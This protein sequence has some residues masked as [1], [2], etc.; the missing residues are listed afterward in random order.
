MYIVQFEDMN[1]KLALSFKEKKNI[2]ASYFYVF[3]SNHQNY[4]LTNISKNEFDL[5]YHNDDDKSKFLR[6][7][8]KYSY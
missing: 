7:L 4:V 2:I 1:F 6:M 3:L 5:I 8:L